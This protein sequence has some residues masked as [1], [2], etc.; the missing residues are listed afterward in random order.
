MV[1]SCVDSEE[2]VNVYHTSSFVV[3]TTVH[4][5]AARS[6]TL[7]G[8][9]PAIVPL[10]AVHAAPGLG[11]DI[12]VALAQASF[13]GVGFTHILL[14]SMFALVALVFITRTK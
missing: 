10:V 6:A 2:V 12:T 8:V 4:E 7:P 5:V 9:P 11:V 1:Y 14:M 13:P 3:F